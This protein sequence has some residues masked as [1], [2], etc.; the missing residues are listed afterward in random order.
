MSE[1]WVLSERRGRVLEITLNR[2]K[3]N[4]LSRAM[5]RAIY[6]ALRQLQDD[7]ELR[8]GVITA[9][10][11]KVF[12]AG[13]DFNEATAPGYDPKDDYDP[14]KGHGPGGF[15]GI[16]RFWDLKKPVIAAVNGAAVGGGF[17]IVLAS[18]IVF[19]AE[20]A[21]F[22]LPEMQRGLLADAGGLQR[23]PRLVPY[24][25]A[26]EMLY[27]GRRME[28]EEA[29]RWGLASKALPSAEL[30]PFV[31]SYAA[32][33]AEGAPL[34]LQAQKELLAAVE[35]LPIREAMELAQPGDPVRLPI[36]NALWKSEDMQEGIK[37]YLEKRPPNFKGR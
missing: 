37:A 24:N 33:L 22:Q 28:A 5:S 1:E 25:V 7:Q 10:G 31:R 23:L 29:V 19:M 4:A 15:A 27:S 30:L 11:E 32:E 17:E 6:G 26:V 3:V 8:V 20:H 13:W 35:V 9:V 2:P 12:S 18:T 21:F 16:T 14:I 34:A 36:Y